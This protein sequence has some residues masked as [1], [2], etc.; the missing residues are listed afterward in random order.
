MRFSI[1]EEL[2]QKGKTTRIW[3]YHCRKIKT[4]TEEVITQEP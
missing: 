4:K 2:K 3:K 1:E